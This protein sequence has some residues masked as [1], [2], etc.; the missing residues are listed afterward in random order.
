MQ[1]LVIL[2]VIAFASVHADTLQLRD[3]RVINGRFISAD[4]NSIRF[5]PNDSNRVRVY[6]RSRVAN[7]IFEGPT[8]AASSSRGMSAQTE[9]P[10][11]TAAPAQTPMPLAT[12][13]PQ[14]TPSANIEAD[15][16]F[17][18]AGT[19]ITVR[20]SDRIDADASQ[21][22]N[23]ITVTLAHPIVINGRTISPAG[24]QATMQVMG[25]L[26]GNR[27]TGSGDITLRLV[28][29]SGSD[30]RVF[31]VTTSDA[32]GQVDRGAHVTAAVDGANTAG[33]GSEFLVGH[34][35]AVQAGTQLTF[36]LQQNVDF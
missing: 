6:S 9:A 36:T 20:T 11:Q 27:L 10:A 3:G 16:N 5:R 31:N 7:I 17:I 29:L 24:A 22:G 15:G 18:P 34:R 13:M 35:V 1:R 2:F 25:V 21:I 12:P 30:G 28:N 26:G 14:S 19:P 4:R 8:G 33:K 23:N 32:V